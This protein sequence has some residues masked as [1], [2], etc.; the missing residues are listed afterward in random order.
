M[1]LTL[2][3]EIGE[4]NYTYFS[5]L[6]LKYIFN[7]SFIA[8]H[9]HLVLISPNYFRLNAGHCNYTGQHNI[10]LANQQTSHSHS[11]PATPPIFK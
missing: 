8:T 9:F 10:H 7:S 4:K 6:P 3:G 5:V 11:F 1:F 2:G